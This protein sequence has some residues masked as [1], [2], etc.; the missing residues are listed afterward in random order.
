MTICIGIDTGGTY[1]DA[2]AYD[3]ESRQVIAKAK[4]RTTKE[5]LSVGVSEALDLLP[6]HLIGQAHIVALSTTLATNACIEDKGGRAKLVL[7]G[8]S[9]KVL[10]R[11]GASDAYGLNEDAVLC[12][13]T[14]STFDGSVVDH[15]DWNR[16][17]EENDAWFRDAQA[18]AVCEVNA[19]RNGAACEREGKRALSARYFVPIVMASELASDL[20]MMQRGATAL[21]NARLLPVIDEFLKAVAHALSKRGVRAPIMI[22]RSD[23][24]I[25]PTE[26]SAKRPVETIL[27]GPAASVHGGRE[28]A[29]REN[30]L[31][32]DMGGTTTDI[33]LVKAGKPAMTKEVRIGS[34]STQVEGVLIDTFGLGGDTRFATREGALV[35][36]NRRVEPLC[37]AAERWP[38]ITERLERLLDCPHK[39]QIPLYEWLFLVKEPNSFERLS[40]REL[41]LIE[42]LRQG[43][44]MVGDTDYFALNS[45]RLESEG[46][47]MRCGLTP[48]DIMH[49]KGDFSRYDKTASLL[50]VRYLCETLPEY[51]NT[52]SGIEALCEDAYLLV[53]KKLYANIARILIS[54]RYPVACKGGIGPQLESIVE[55]E[56]ERACK[57][58]AGGALFDLDLVSKATLVGIGAPTHVFL[59]RV[60]AKLGTD[61]IIPPHAEVANAVGAVAAKIIAESS[62]LVRP[63]YDSFGITGYA[64]HAADGVHRIKSKEAALSV[65]RDKAEG[66]AKSEARKRGATGNLPCSTSSSA[67]TTR[68]EDG[69]SIDLGTTVSARVE[70]GF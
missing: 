42:L 48:T 12:L 51:D 30:C 66:Q 35:L 1:T 11:I 19:I 13:S 20:N 63:V 26:L 32:V 56:W 21:L 57:G 2:V 46:I 44:C 17:T 58:G 60:A 37:A 28:L 25:M 49:V 67:K 62:V 22:L 10:R 36:A 18:L 15:P 41:D 4:A 69:Q 39:S 6:H 55:C 5:N 27:S 7:M 50:G 14:K 23:G 70:V 54:D 68:A 53:E 47:V 40:Q 3:S 16:V 38:E 9:Q 29:A 43:P 61:C 8:T 31:I 24:G 33:S 52:A 65:A 34:W 64:V 45:D 59:P